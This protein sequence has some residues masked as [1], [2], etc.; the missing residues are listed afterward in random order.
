MKK[1]DSLTFKMPVYIGV[2]MVFLIV[3]INVLSISISR[4][5]TKSTLEKVLTQTVKGYSDNIT[6]YIELRNAQT[7]AVASD[8]TITS[9]TATKAEKIRALTNYKNNLD[10]KN[11]GLIDLSGQAI[12]YSGD[13]DLSNRAYFINGK[14]GEIT[15]SEP[16]TSKQDGTSIIVAARP[17]YNDYGKVKGVVYI[18][19]DTAKMNKC[20]DEL[21]IGETGSGFVISKEG[22]ILSH[23]D[24]EHV[25]N[26]DNYLQLGEADNSYKG[27]ATAV[28]EMLEEKSGLKVYD[29][30]NKEIIS[31]FCE[32]EGSDGWIFAMYAPYDEFLEEVNQGSY[33]IIIVSCVILVIFIIMA[34][35]LSKKLTKPV[36]KITDRMVKLSNG[37]LKSGIDPINSKSE[38]GTLYNSC[39]KTIDT[40]K[41]YIF[42]ISDTLKQMA[43]GD[44]TVN[45][46]QNYVGDFAPIKT[47]MTDILKSL[48]DTLA[49]INNASQQV[50]TSAE[51]VSSGAQALAAGTTEQASSIQELTASITDV[52]SQID[53]NTKNVNVANDYVKEVNDGVNTSNVQMKEMLT[54]M[55][56]IDSSSAEI[57]KIIKVIDD[58]A[59]QTNILALNAAVEASRAGTAGKGFAV[60]AEEVRNL[61]SKSANAANQTN[62]LINNSISS[63]EKGKEIAKLTAQALEEV[64]NK[65]LKV[66]DIIEKI[67]VASNYQNNAMSQISQG[68]EQ[69]SQVIQTNTATSEESAAASEELSHQSK[70]LKDKV[71]N[72]KLKK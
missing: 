14:N 67:K 2:A 5:D 9:D 64:K 41:T 66:N 44:M 1:K 27:I 11:V 61:A 16:V 33:I 23:R 47:A 57:S 49:T 60:V 51:Q 13:V 40:L 30:N 54:A 39:Q 59:F 50:D 69:I 25:I 17:I 65:T 71:S 36:I 10:V 45:I 70:T 6:E 37:D 19:D 55:E 31:S 48:N 34:I 68:I 15:V 52:S 28:S 72:F 8:L 42:D 63:V 18:S 53:S 20:I 43:A 56:E 26:Q 7:L 46:E 12:S 24:Y 38:L 29:Q 4:S 22:T 62:E 58:I 32:V 3:I 35:M 21:V